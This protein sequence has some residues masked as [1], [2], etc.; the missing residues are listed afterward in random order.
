MVRL[1]F[2]LI[3]I[4]LFSAFVLY[5]QNDSAIN[6]K[7][8]ELKKLKKEISSLENEIK[9]K[10]KKEKQS[11]SILQNYDKQNF[12]INKIL[13]KYRAEEKQ[14]ADEIT[15][16]QKKI[17]AL[18]EEISRLQSNYA[19]YVNSIY[20]KAKPSE[21]AVIFDAESISQ[22]LRRIFYL[23]KFSESREQD[24][25]KFEAAKSQLA[26]E[27]KM[28]EKAKAEK[29][30]LIRMKESDEK[31]LSK[32]SSDRKQILN[33]IKK[34]KAVLKKELDAKKKAE[35]TIRNLIAK[36][37][38]EKLEREKKAA[39]LA[40]KNK[41]ENKDRVIPKNL[42]EFEKHKGKLNWP[43]SSG[44]IIRKFGEN[45][46]LILNTVTL[47]Y[48][49]D[50]KVVSDLQVRSVAVG[51][52]STIEWIPGY[53]SIL[54]ISHDDEFRTV[55]SH[56]DNIYVQEG[57]KVNTGQVIATIGESLEGNVLHFEIWNSRT[58]QNPEVWL[59][60]K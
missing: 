28:L 7:Q 16:A 23:R 17:N 60:K 13:T 58:N 31:I 50:I 49:I 15:I 33:V 6:E 43:V 40:L 37:I 18:S 3:T 45:K 11:Y 14:K 56:L 8:S 59:V 22:A 53:G 10:T 9:S 35:V 44:R 41:G 47:N 39:E 2:S 20:R 38:E 54:I 29:L 32:K 5:P 55:Y 42:S 30:A 46:N 36:L 24:L 12:L 25:K 27:K 51:T 26:S 34:D 48:G 57:E 21:F 19:K 52:V 4:I 1:F